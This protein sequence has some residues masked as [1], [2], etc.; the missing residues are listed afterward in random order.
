MQNVFSL[1]NQKM[2]RQSY[3]TLVDVE[4][5][6]QSFTESKMEALKLDA[7]YLLFFFFILGGSTQPKCL[8]FVFSQQLLF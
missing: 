4:R 7:N 1:Q 6:V 3:L 5:W 2:Y 8:F